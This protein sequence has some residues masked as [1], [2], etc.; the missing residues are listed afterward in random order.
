MKL[1]IGKIIRL[2][3]RIF[4]SYKKKFFYSLF[5]PTIYLT[6]LGHRRNVPHL[7]FQI[8]SLARCLT[9]QQL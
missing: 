6:T 8:F 2:K 1:E 3:L 5:K 7:L 9:R 4:Y